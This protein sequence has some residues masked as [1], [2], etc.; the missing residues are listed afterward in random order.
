V[1]FLVTVLPDRIAGYRDQDV[2][3]FI[4]DLR[5]FLDCEERDIR[6]RNYAAQLARRTAIKMDVET[7]A[8]LADANSSGCRSD[9]N[10]FDYHFW[11]TGARWRTAQ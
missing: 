11:L 9:E 5:E 10:A 4:S 8:I 2:E 6:R 1:A 7:I 3:Y